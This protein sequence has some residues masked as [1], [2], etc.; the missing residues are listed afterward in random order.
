MDKSILGLAVLWVLFVTGSIGSVYA[1]SSNY[2]DDLFLFSRDSILAQEDGHHTV[3]LESP[4]NESNTN[5]DNNSLQFVYNHTGTLTGTVNCTLY[6]DGVPVNY[7]TNIS[8]TTSTPVYSNISFSEAQH[9]WWVNCS[10]GTDTDSSIDAG[11]NYTFNCIK[12]PQ[13]NYTNST[14]PNDTTT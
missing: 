8:A 12:Y 14:P 5:N 7:T 3:Y 1:F 9:W 6:L 10:N 2:F 11:F 4:L 13:I